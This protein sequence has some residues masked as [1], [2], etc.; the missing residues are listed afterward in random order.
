LDCRGDALQ[1]QA[2]ILGRPTGIFSG[3][4]KGKGD[5]VAVFPANGFIGF[6]VGAGVFGG[7]VEEDPIEAGEEFAWVLEGVSKSA[8]IFLPHSGREFGDEATDQV[9]LPPEA[10]QTASSE[11]IAPGELQQHGGG[12]D[13][14]WGGVL[15]EG[16]ESAL[17]LCRDVGLV[18][19]VFEFVEDLE[20]LPRLARETG[21]VLADMVPMSLAAEALVGAD[22]L[23]DV[24]EVTHRSGPRMRWVAVEFESVARGTAFSSGAAESA[25]GGHGM[26][27]GVG[28]GCGE[29]ATPPGLKGKWGTCDPGLL[30]TPGYRL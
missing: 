29:S 20:L 11:G 12:P 27:P 5:G 21:A 3:I 8:H 16:F 15:D 28:C 9:G 30:R 18:E 14:F 22:P 6:G 7:Q 4:T 10:D 24:A 25:E 23:T 19:H 26:L 2:R 17:I 13:D 1:A